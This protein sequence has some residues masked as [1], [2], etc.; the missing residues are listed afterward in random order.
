MIL[1]ISEVFDPTTDEVMRWLRK[2]NQKAIRISSFKQVIDEGVSLSSENNFGSSAILGVD[3]RE[4][5]SVW[6][7]RRPEFSNRDRYVNHH[8]TAFAPFVNAMNNSLVTEEHT[9]NNFFE[10]L[11]DDRKIL[12]SLKTSSLNK[13]YQLKMASKIGMTIPGTA[14]LTSK[15]EVESFAI[16]HGKIIIKPLDNL[17]VVI[18]EGITY[19]NYTKMVNEDLLK[20]VP[21]KFSPALFQGYVEKEFEVRSFFLGKEEYSMAIFSQKNDKTRVDFRKYDK[22]YPNRRVPYKLPKHLY[23]MVL[24]FMDAVKINTGSF[25]FIY[26]SKGEHIFLEVN[27]VGQ[28]GMV[29]VPCNYFIEKRIAQKLSA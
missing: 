9:V 25:D 19:Y 16:K 17:S 10:D 27:P 28:F 18:G 12:G 26:S 15:K 8:S 5:K 1:I 4:I 22:V 11:L 13:L 7:R 21:E 20:R 29:S 3:I 14:V 23:Q 6:F 24:E 2:H